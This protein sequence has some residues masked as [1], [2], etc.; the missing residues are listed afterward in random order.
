MRATIKPLTAVKISALLISL[1]SFSYS[2]GQDIAFSENS[3]SQLFYSDNTSKK[4]T[5][6]PDCPV[7]VG[8]LRYKSS[9]SETITFAQPPVLD[10]FYYVLRL[11]YESGTTPRQIEVK[12]GS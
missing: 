1:L 2:S 3:L 4:E 7:P 6:Y 12:E 8:V 10:Q 9:Q 5:E 11:E